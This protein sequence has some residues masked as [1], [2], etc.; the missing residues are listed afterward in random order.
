M[1]WGWFSKV[2]E[3][4]HS[5]TLRSKKNVE[6]SSDL[7]ERG[8]KRTNKQTDKRRQNAFKG[9]RKSLDFAAIAFRQKID[10]LKDCNK[11]TKGVRSF[12]LLN[13]FL[14]ILKLLIKV[15]NTLFFAGL[16][17][18][19]SSSRSHRY[20][21]AAARA[22]HLN[23]QRSPT[24]LPLPLSLSLSLSLSHTHTLSLSFSQSLFLPETI[25]RLA[26]LPSSR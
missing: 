16:L 12:A 26:P 17:N 24:P 25:S 22:A 14:F 9:R 20:P 1:F 5:Q 7:R 3:S 11:V 23:H 13:I 15:L 21:Q 8:K 6:P 2:Y 10:F 4:L 19:W 18:L